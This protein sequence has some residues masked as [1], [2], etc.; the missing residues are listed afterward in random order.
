MNKESQTLQTLERGLKILSYFRV[1]KTEWGIT[2]LS[3]E[4][5]LS[6]SIVH[7]LVSTLEQEGFLEQNP[8][9]NRYRLG[10]KLFE[11]GTLAV[12]DLDVRHFAF[13]VMQE[14]AEKTGETVNLTVVNYQTFEGVCIATVDSPQSVKFTTRVGTSLPL[15]WGASHKILLAFL[16]N[17]E[18]HKVIETKGLPQM[19]E[20]TITDEEKLWHEINKIRANG[21]AIS[22]EEVD[23]GA[24]A[25][26]AP[27]F[28]REGKI[29]AGLT[30]VGPLYRLTEE[31]ITT[32]I[33]L[34]CERAAWI[35][36]RMGGYWQQIDKK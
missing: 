8:I 7:R 2:E 17:Q 13:P 31:K 24:A 35:T 9:T 15:H 23:I 34:L 21:Y 1:G 30:V 20:N 14:L 25:V 32:I 33:P 27:I 18:I 22:R 10:L 3:K 6:K 5:S 29:A 12:M 28:D 16:T 19:T 26:A 4:L 11:L 36:A